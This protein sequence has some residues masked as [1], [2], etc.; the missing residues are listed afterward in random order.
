MKTKTHADVAAD[1]S[2][3]LA[4]GGK[5]TECKTSRRKVRMEAKGKQKLSFGWAAPKNR[6]SMMYDSI[7]TK[8]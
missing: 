4:S 1:V 3:F 7:E 6:P 8:L 2:A 5:V